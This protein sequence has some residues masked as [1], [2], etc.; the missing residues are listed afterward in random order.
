MVDNPFI[1]SSSTSEVKEG[2][3]HKQYLIDGKIVAIGVIDI[4]PTCLSSAYFCYD[5]D[6]KFLNFGTFSA[7]REI[8]DV[9]KYSKIKADLKYYYMGYYVN[10]CR[11]MR[12]K[13]AFRP[14]ELLCDYSHEWVSERKLIERE[15]R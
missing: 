15:R 13:A 2:A 4:L 11:K 8:E 7:L 12:Y 10:N 3:I 6:Y 14:S 1:S 5:P 9:R